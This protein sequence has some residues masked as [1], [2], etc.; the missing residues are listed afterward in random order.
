MRE[1]GASA[2]WLRIGPHNHD[3]RFPR[4]E[5]DN[6]ILRNHKREDV[7]LRAYLFLIYCSSGVYHFLRRIMQDEL[8]WLNR[9]DPNSYTIPKLPAFVKQFSEPC[10][11][12][13]A[14][15]R[16]LF[17]ADGRS[18]TALSWMRHWVESGHETHL[19]ST[20]PCDPPPG[21]ASFH[22][23]RWLLVDLPA[24]RRISLELQD[25]SELNGR[26][27][28]THAQSAIPSWPVKSTFIR[29]TIPEIGGRDPPGPCPCSA[30][31]V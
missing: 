22:C 23:S 30:D 4:S 16:L 29:N 24:S 9:T 17:V 15:M 12:Y 27:R 21:L 18:P 28:T 11:W 6:R 8:F 10:L 20:Y 2:R 31:P 25:F 1:A 14:P 19:V 3:H 5:P 13:S 26:F 7:F